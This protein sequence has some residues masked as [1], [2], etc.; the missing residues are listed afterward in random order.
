M[1]HSDLDLKSFPSGLGTC[2]APGT[3]D[4]WVSSGPVPLI[5]MTAFGLNT[6]SYG[7]VAMSVVWHIDGHRAT[8]FQMAHFW[9]QRWMIQS[10]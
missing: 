2:R 7:R 6:L 8:K 9:M 4:I 3:K 10:S 1:T 5:L